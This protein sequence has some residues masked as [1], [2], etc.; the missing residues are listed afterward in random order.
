MQAASNSP[1]IIRGERSYVFSIGGRNTGD[2]I[3]TSNFCTA[4]L[5]F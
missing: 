1:I 5:E 2:T 3:L 4:L